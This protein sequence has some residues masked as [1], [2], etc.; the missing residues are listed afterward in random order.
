V[1]DVP[2]LRAA[3]LRIAELEQILRHMFTTTMAVHLYAR[4]ID[5]TPGVAEW[6]HVR[7]MIEE[8]VNPYGPPNADE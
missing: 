2:E 5:G 4:D 7:H 1:D 8:T 6:R 3:R